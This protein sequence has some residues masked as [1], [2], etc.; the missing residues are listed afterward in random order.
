M[1]C[2]KSGEGRPFPSDLSFFVFLV[3]NLNRWIYFY[4]RLRALGALRLGLVGKG[5]RFC[6]AFVHGRQSSTVGP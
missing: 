3:L 4:R 2:T 6:F 1:F 5:S